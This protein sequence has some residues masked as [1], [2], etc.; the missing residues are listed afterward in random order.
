[1]KTYLTC[2]N[3]ERL[4]MDDQDEKITLAILLGGIWPCNPFMAELA[5]MTPST[6][7][8]FMDMADDFV[9]TENTLQALADPRKGEHKTENK[10]NL[11]D[12]KPTSNHHNRRQE[13]R[14]EHSIRLMHNNMNV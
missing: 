11:G 1:M 5:R 2:F 6:L 14:P 10:A 3:K 7:R 9:N 4:M 8:E 13:E 12:E